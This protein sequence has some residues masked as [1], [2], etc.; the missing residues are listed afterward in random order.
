MTNSLKL[1][2]DKNGIA[3]VVFD[4]KGEKVNK[5]SA[6]VLLE[7]EKLLFEAKTNDK[8]K[9]LIFSSN[10]KNIFIAGADINEIKDIKG[11]SEAAEKSSF[12]Q[13][14]LNRI[15]DLPF[16]TIAF[17]NGACVGGGLE[18]ALACRYRIVASNDKTK[19]GL[20][21]V[22][23]GII[24]GFGGTWRL[25]KLVGLKHSLAMILS[26]K[27]INAK[28]SYKIG[29]ADD[30]VREEFSS[31]FLNDFIELIL[32]KPKDNKYLLKRNKS[33]RS[34]FTKETLLLGKYFIYRYVK[35]DLIK[36]TK[37]HYPA[38]LSALEVIEE[39]YDFNDDQRDKGLKLEAK[40]FSKLAVSDISKNLIDLFFISEEIKKDSG[41]NKDVEAYQV[42]EAGLVG[43]GIMGGGIAWLFSNYNISIRMKDISN[44]AIALGFKQVDKV[45]N[46]LKKI[47]KYNDNEINLRVNN[48]SSTLKYE[49][50][51]SS[52]IVVEAIIEDIKI[53]K[54]TISELEKYISKNTII[55][56]NTSSLSITKMAQSLKNPERFIGMHFFNP[57]NR[58]PLV[59][60]IQ[61]EKTSQEAVATVV[62]LSKK[63]GKTPIVVKDVPGFL[64]NRILIPYINEAGFLI[65]EGADLKLVD[66]LI[67]DF[68][69]PMGPFTLADT[70]GIDVGYKVA[71]I[72]EEG[73]G[74][75]MK[76]C[77]L[78]EEISLD[79][80]L[81]G[82]KSDE[83]FFMYDKGKQMEVNSKITKIISNNGLTK[84]EF[85]EEDVIDRCI[86][87]MINE[88]AKCLEEKVVKNPRYL[89]MAMIM[90]TGFPPFRGGLLKY[91]NNLGIKKV[92]SRMKNLNKTYGKRFQPSA[93]LLSMEKEGKSFY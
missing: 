92:V 65:E 4:L 56:S 87:I 83:G 1:K 17:I 77:E 57:V 20:P 61:G 52:D 90:G 82:K 24:P 58:M 25:P 22:S 54:D 89:D 62:A 12:G 79:K 45:Y 59:E 42:Q 41:A 71:K 36:K 44:Q 74:N 66:D 73:Y 13:E 76:V 19:L 64:V 8:I 84:L 70:V 86:F 32:L 72:L 29:L 33:R 40:Y 21:E 26:G 88:A 30:M 34:R 80:N 39:T 43:A 5:L 85:F 63:L 7:L 2:I 31:K 75:R 38:V 67:V 55:A 46:Q 11:K 81:L 68:G 78:L 3:N 15:E 50:F 93:L 23:L 53:K 14:I 18:F 49:G 6:K 10:K 51:N 69:M 28:K 48:I 47:R 35:K 27:P 9:V 37:G 16:P 60:V 91:A